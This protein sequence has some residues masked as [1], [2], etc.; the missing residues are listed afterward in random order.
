MSVLFSK[1]M[2]QRYPKTIVRFLY[3]PSCPNA[4]KD[5]FQSLLFAHFASVISLVLL[6]CSTVRTKLEYTSELWSPY[7]CKDK[8]LLEN[9]QRRATK[10]ILNY[11]KDMSYKDRLR[12]LN[13]LPLEYRRDLKDQG[14]VDLGHHDLF[15]QTEIHHRT[16]NSCKFTY[17]LSYV[18]LDMYKNTVKFR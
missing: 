10:F 11:S 8:P 16:R 3:Y 5:V 14:H 4:L 9:V 13:L 15:Q 1:K 18:P 12:K 2:T 6:Y 7:T 17:L